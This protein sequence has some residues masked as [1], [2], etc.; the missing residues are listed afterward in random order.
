MSAAETVIVG[1]RLPRI[2]S[3]DHRA[4]YE[5]AVSWDDA[6]RDGATDIVDLSPLVFRLKFCAPLRDDGAL[7][8][9]VHVL[10]GGA[11]I[12][13]GET[14]EV[15]M[16]AIS[17]LQLAEKVQPAWLPAEEEHELYQIDGRTA[18]A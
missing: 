10:H 2:R 12:A 13:W 3:I 6:T 11:A 18:A 7:R 14:D 9:N 1:Q 8:R 4:G 16:A 15:G 5:V 17:V